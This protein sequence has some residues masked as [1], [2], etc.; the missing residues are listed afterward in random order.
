MSPC[1]PVLE[2]EV[3]AVLRDSALGRIVELVEAAQASKA[4]IQCTADRI[5]PW[6]VAVTLG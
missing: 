6:F 2:V 1:S 5:V 3:S 4:P